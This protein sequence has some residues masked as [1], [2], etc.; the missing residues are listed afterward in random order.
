MEGRPTLPVDA[1]ELVHV[2]GAGRFGGATR[3][4]PRAVAATFVLVAGIAATG[5]GASDKGTQPA[6]VPAGVADAVVYRSPTCGCCK[7][8]EEYLRRHGSRVTSEVT[9]DMESVRSQHRIPVEAQSCHTAV[10][11]DYVIEGHVPVEA[12]EKLFTE[13]PDAD[14]I[15][16]AGMPTNAPGMGEPNG[17]PIEVV[18]LD[19]GRVT[20]FM[21]V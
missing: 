10:I 9:E 13:R 6:P 7:S 11:G 3:R 16:V 8:Y 21:R 1:A 17:E 2:R 14:G 5:C 19:E 18:L 20:P 4:N 15:A 12:I